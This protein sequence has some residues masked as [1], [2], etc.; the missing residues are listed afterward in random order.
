MNLVDTCVWVELFADTSTGR[1]YRRL[2]ETPA[3]V[4]VPT[5][6]LFELRRWALRELGDAE[7]DRVIA[8][9]RNAHIV[10]L[11]EPIALIAADLTVRYKLPALDALIYATA[12]HHGAT[13]VTCDAHFESLPGVEYQAKLAA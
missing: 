8:A 11:G 6:V 4:L 13:L 1:R 10:P 3:Q 5:L 7:A 12:L 9:T 2:F